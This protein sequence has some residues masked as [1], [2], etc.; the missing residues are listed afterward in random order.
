MHKESVRTESS[1]INAS[2]LNVSFVLFLNLIRTRGN[3][4]M[5]VL[6]RPGNLVKVALLLVA[7]RL[8]APSAL[9]EPRLVLR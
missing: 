7:V 9:P 8:L 1:S 6:L 3:S 5:A 4:K 2:K